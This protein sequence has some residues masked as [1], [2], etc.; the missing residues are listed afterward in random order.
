MNVQMTNTFTPIEILRPTVAEF[1]CG[2][3]VAAPRF[4]ERIGALRPLLVSDPF[5]ARRVDQLV[6]IVAKGHDLAAVVE[7]F[8]MA[9]AV[10]NLLG[11]RCFGPRRMS[12][13]LYLPRDLGR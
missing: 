3:I 9:D 5:N 8:P 2:T 6:E 7:Q 1:G 10:R 12:G 11:R 4:A 13:G